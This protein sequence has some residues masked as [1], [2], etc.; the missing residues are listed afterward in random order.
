MRRKIGRGI[1]YCLAIF[2]GIMTILPLFITFICSVK[3]NVGINLSMLS[4]PKKWLWS[5]YVD[6]F[7]VAHIGK[8]VANSIFLGV[9]TTLLVSVVALLAAYILSRKRFKL[10]S[11]ISTLFIVGVMVPVHCTIIPISNLAVELHGKNTMWMLILIYTAFNLAQAIFLFTGYMNGIDR[12]LDEAAIMDGCNDFQVL[13][14][15][16]MPVC[17]PIISTEAIL[18]FISAYGELIF[19]MTLLSDPNKYTASRAMLVFSS[20]HDQLLGPIFASVIVVVL[21][22]LILYTIFHE[23]VQNGMMTGAVKG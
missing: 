10:R 6:A 20:G 5:N 13:F 23:K 16:L 18:A 21:P 17:M 2:W 11:A 7:Q 19:S 1:I 8:A 12:E 22:M 9:S 4:L 3:D 15:V 14:Q